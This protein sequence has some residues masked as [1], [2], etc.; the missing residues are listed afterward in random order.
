MAILKCEGKDTPPK[1]SRKSHPYDK[2]QSISNI[3]NPN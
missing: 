3:K 2:S 1:N